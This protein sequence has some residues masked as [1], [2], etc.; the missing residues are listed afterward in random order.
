M[1][2]VDLNTNWNIST[3]GESYVCDLPH[4]VTANAA[5]DYACAFGESNGY[6]PDARAVFV[7]DL[8]KTTGE[9]LLAIS[10]ACGYGDI[11]VNDVK[12]GTTSGYAPCVF[13]LAD[14]LHG[15]HNSL[16][17][18]LFTS[19]AMSDKYLGLGIAGGV[20]LIE[21]DAECDI[22]YNSLFVKTFTTNGRTYADVSFDVYNHGDAAK[23]FT[24]EALVQNARGKRAGKKQRKVLVR[25]GSVKTV[26]VRVRI[27]NPYE[28]STTDPYVYTATVKLIPTDAGEDAASVASTRFGIVKRALYSGRGL[29]INNKKTLLMGAYVSHADAAL[30]GVSLYCNETRR[31]NALKAVGYNA[32]HFV[33]CPTDAMLDACDDTGMFAFVDLNSCLVQSKAPLGGVFSDMSVDEKI[34]AL[35]NHPSVTLYGVADDVP[36]CYDRHDGHELIRAI[37]ESIRQYDDTRP[38]TV[39]AREFVPT[40]TELENAGCKKRVYESDAAAINAGREKSLFESLTAGAFDSVDICGFNYLYPL[41]ETERNKRDRLIVGA[42]THSDHAFDSLDATEKNDRVIGDFNDCGI[43]YPGGGRLNEICTVAGDLDGTCR[44]KPQAQYKRVLLGE[45]NTAYIA[46]LDPETDEPTAMWNWPR[47]LGQRVTVNVYTSGDVVALYLDG[48]IVGRRLAG[49]INKHVATFKTDYYP[50][51]LEAIAYYKGTE[52]ARARLKSASTPK[53][54]KLSA[55]EKNLSVGRGD[56]G[57]VYIDVCDRDGEPV[58]YAMRNLTASVTGGELVAFINADPMLRKQEFDI[59]PAYNGQALAVVKPDPAEN[60]AVVKISGDG[61]LASRISFKIKN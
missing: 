15:A 49:K 1:K 47:H 29:Y 40:P 54:L 58:P 46:V 51:T 34:K 35:R 32:V 19:P 41:Y 53:T 18:E 57:F 60:K 22:E 25:A 30:G 20:K 27:N 7:R 37:A 52:C 26:E 38:V 5:R 24:A 50:G 42:R 17:I 59:C 55:Y 56:L 36:E 9:T 3:G 6:I 31:L 12:I 61:L 39:S 14:L 28:W 44:E 16:R 45:R 23:K 21:C 4:D 2:S 33:E 10:G 8:P 43:D 13:Y 48:R 11:F